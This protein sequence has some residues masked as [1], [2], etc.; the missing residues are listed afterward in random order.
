MNSVFSQE[1]GKFICV[2]LDDILVFSEMFEDYIQHIK[3]S[4][5]RLREA[6]LYR[7][8]HKCEFMQPEVE[9]LG[10]EVTKEGLKPSPTKVQAIAEW[11]IPKTVKDVWSFFGLA[12]YYWRFIKDFSKIAKP[13]IELTKDKVKWCWDK[14]EDKNL[15]AA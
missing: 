15:L 12:S 2:Y 14:E 3:T 13:L 4:L 1:W 7:Y 8:I 11:P 6:K 5:Q 9:Y 10:F